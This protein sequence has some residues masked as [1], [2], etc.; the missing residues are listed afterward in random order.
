MDFEKLQDP[1]KP[2]DQVY[3]PDER[4]KYFTGSL[5][6]V[7]A[8]VSTITLNENAPLE[9]RQL[10]ETAKNLSLYSWFAY[11]FHQ[12]SELICFTALEMALRLRYED[13][14]PDC[15]KRMMLKGLMIHAKN[16]MWITNDGFP[17]LPETA[18]HSAHYKKRTSLMRTHDFDKN[19][20]LRIEEPTEQ[21]IL[22]EM[23]NVDIVDTVVKTAANIRNDLAHGSN[24]LHPHSIATLRRTSEIINQI[25]PIHKE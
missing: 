22:E 1:L 6:D 19:P 8:E 13:E 21:E 11:R 4:Q 12:V 17:S 9:V 24:T 10:F 7:H 15:K 20:T 3:E 2:L 23:K 16:E 14:N 25:Y 5:A 18:K